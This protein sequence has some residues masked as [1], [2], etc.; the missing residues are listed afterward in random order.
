MAMSFDRGRFTAHGSEL[1]LS[2]MVDVHSAAA[3]QPVCASSH[4]YP[5]CLVWTPIY[6]L[7]WVAPY[8]GHVGIADMSG[9]TWDFAGPRH[10]GVD[11]MAFGW[12]SRYV[13]L[14]LASV[15]L[16]KGADGHCLPGASQSYDALLVQRASYFEARVHYDFMTWNC[17]S[18][19]ASML[20]ELNYP[21][22][23][24]TSA[25]GGWSVVSIALLIFVRGRH[26]GAMGVV[27]QWGGSLVVSGI[28]LSIG[29]SSGSWSHLSTFLTAAA[30]FN[31]FFILWFG[32]LAG[33]GCSSQYGAVCRR[34]DCEED[35]PPEVDE[36]EHL[37]AFG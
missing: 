19:V 22:S 28:V 3:P 32:L 14:D 26:V 6:P 15:P 4:R 7:T 30:C 33:L 8:V 35:E 23:R 25:L 12:P 20:N 18:F 16:E 27:K 13:Q 11:N 34:L 31:L 37:S 36:E 10:I 5:H 24:L 1:D 17:H 29:L 2:R 9:R 21:R